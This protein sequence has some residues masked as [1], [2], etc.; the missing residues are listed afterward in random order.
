MKLVKTITKYFFEIDLKLLVVNRFQVK[1]KTIK[2]IFFKN[3]KPKKKLP[4]LQIHCDCPRNL[5]Q[6]NFA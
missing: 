3:G 6:N 2:S 1:Q 5:E 4:R